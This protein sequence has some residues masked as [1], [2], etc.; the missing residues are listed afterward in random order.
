[1]F[2]KASFLNFVPSVF[3]TTN[4]FFEKLGI[5]FR[6]IQ[7]YETRRRVSFCCFLLFFFK[8]KYLL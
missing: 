2:I 8:K 4:G 6:Q 5:Q 3:A 1:M 7:F